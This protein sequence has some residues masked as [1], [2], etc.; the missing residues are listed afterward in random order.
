[1]TFLLIPHIFQTS[2]VFC[3]QYEVKGLLKILMIRANHELTDT[4]VTIKAHG[5]PYFGKSFQ[6]VV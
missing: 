4:D 3:S 1:M 5:M 6:L 2:F